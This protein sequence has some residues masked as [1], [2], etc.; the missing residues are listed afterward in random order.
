[1]VA[2]H[3]KLKKQN[4]SALTLSGTGRSM[5]RHPVSMRA[6]SVGGMGTPLEPRRTVLL[7]LLVLM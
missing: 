3:E 6:F 7:V 2:Q 4:V 1:M 5:T